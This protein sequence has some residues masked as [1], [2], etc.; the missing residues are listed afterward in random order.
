MVAEA[1]PGI[2]EDLRAIQQVHG[3]LPASALQAL[4]ERSQTPLYHLQ[5]VASFFPHFRLSPPPKVDVR[6]CADMSCHLHGAD[7]LYWSAQVRVEY[8]ESDSVVVQ[9]ASCLGQCDRAPAAAVNDAIVTRLTPAAL[10]EHIDTALAN[11]SL[12]HPERLT[13]T[14]RLL[15]DPYDP[16]ERY[17]V[18]RSFVSDTD[19]PRML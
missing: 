5:G 7:D 11:G 13:S 17:G 6:V 15:V 12:P 16:S 10:S 9:R 19:E 18:L 3:Y 2:I 14:E 8:G 4:S 1:R